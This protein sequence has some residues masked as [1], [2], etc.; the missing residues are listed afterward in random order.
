MTHDI[1][2]ALKLG[3]KVLIM[4]Q[5]QIQQFDTPENIFKNPANDFVKKLVSKN[6]SYS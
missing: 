4:D 6:E 5:G 1:Q 3:T 2:E